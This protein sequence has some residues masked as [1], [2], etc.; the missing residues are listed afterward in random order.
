MPRPAYWPFRKANPKL[1]SSR[2]NSWPY[3]RS[4]CS[5]GD[6]REK[7][8]LHAEAKTSTKAVSTMVIPCHCGS[9]YFPPLVRSSTP[10]N[11]P[12]GVAPICHRKIGEGWPVV[13]RPQS[14]C[15]VSRLVTVYELCGGGNGSAATDTSTRA[16]R[17]VPSIV[18]SR[19]PAPLQLAG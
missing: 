12:G 9:A 14:R 15:T 3:L 5:D 4:C 6:S 10:Q 19:Q 18:R 11:I 16:A 8:G 17:G 1:R 13:W 7:M 2:Y